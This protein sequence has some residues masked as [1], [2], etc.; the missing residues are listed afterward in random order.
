MNNDENMA[1]TC[2]SGIMV[3]SFEGGF[4][5]FFFKLLVYTA[6]NMLLCQTGPHGIV[7]IM[8]HG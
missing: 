8:S 2:I 7:L 5:F 1:Q 3:E 6:V 4:C